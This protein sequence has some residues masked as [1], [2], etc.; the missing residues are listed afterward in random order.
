MEAVNKYNLKKNAKLNE[1]TSWAKLLDILIQTEFKKKNTLREFPL[2]NF[3]GANCS[4]LRET[5]KRDSSTPAQ[6][7]SF[8]NQDTQRAWPFIQWSYGVLILAP[9]STQVCKWPAGC[10]DKG[11]V[12]DGRAVNS[13]VFSKLYL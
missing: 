3:N 10:F 2:R 13:R 11:Q 5:L 7:P 9:F 6:S 8:N 12:C 1:R 4:W